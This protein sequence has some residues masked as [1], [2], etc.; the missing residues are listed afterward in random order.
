[1]AAW[2]STW[3]SS[4]I[5]GCYGVSSSDTLSTGSELQSN[6]SKI[7]NTMLTSQNGEYVMILQ[8]DGNL[9][10]YNKTNWNPVWAFN[11]ADTRTGILKLAM[12]N[13]GNLVIYD[14][15]G[16][17]IWASDTAG[18]GSNLSLKL[19]NDGTAMIVNANNAL[20]WLTA[21]KN[22]RMVLTKANTFALDSTEGNANGTSPWFY[23]NDPANKNQ[24]FVYDLS[25]NAIKWNGK[26]LDVPGGNANNEQTLQWWDCNNSNAQKWT[27]D[28]TTLLW[29]SALNN[30]CIDSFGN[31]KLHNEVKPILYDC[32]ATNENQMWNAPW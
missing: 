3:D 14:S 17:P 1:M 11:T 13:D 10:I 26:C 6:N 23:G 24:T 25:T 20:V 2:A 4:H 5:V 21:P 16:A 18:K 9:V 27:Y 8:K 19:N 32:S 31:S 28:P 29:K 12:Q 22:I 7:G 30:K 15:A